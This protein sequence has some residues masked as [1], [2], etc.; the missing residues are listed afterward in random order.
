MC[1]TPCSLHESRVLIKTSNCLMLL[2]NQLEIVFQ[3]L[4]PTSQGRFFYI[5]VAS[6]GEKK[7]IT[8]SLMGNNRH[9]FHYNWLLNS[10][11]STHVWLTQL[12]QLLVQIEQY[13]LCSREACFEMDTVTDSILYCLD[14]CSRYC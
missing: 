12:Q 11:V 10:Y 7:Y 8:W 9:W 1:T 4:Y 14:I 3:A 13:W 5:C 2:K 6:L